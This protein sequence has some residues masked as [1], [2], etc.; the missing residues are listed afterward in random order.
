MNGDSAANGA[1]GSMVDHLGRPRVAVTG[2]GVNTPAGNDVAILWESLLAG[3]S[4]A[5]DVE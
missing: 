1:P 5:V 3:R 4:V 2:L